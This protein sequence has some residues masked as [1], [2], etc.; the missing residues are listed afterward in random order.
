MLDLNESAENLTDTC[1]IIVDV[2]DFYST[3]SQSVTCS[4]AK[5]SNEHSIMSILEMNTV[6]SGA[7][8]D[9]VSECGIFVRLK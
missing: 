6:N 5:Q 2:L 4:D 9:L 1:K 3:V 8:C 7:G